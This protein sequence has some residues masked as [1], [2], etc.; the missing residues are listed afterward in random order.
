[1][2]WLAPERQ[3]EVET[4]ACL[5]RAPEICVE[6]WSPSNR[7]GEIER[8]RELYL[9]AGA[10]EVWVCGLDGGM[11]FYSSS[12]GSLLGRSELCP[13]FP[14]AVLPSRETQDRESR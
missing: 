1:V 4:V 8:K 3:A 7:V 2:C 9:E 13:A 5:L 6:I 11:Q 10:R 12:G 14:G